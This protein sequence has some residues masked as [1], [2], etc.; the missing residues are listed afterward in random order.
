MLET[1]GELKVHTTMLD[2]V[3]TMPQTLFTINLVTIT[4]SWAEPKLG[5]TT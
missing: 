2:I 4:L 1:C 3:A 5:F